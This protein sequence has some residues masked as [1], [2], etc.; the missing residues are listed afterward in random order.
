MPA[1]NR[2]RET[3]FTALLDGLVLCMAWYIFTQVKPELTFKIVERDGI[4]IILAGAIHT[5]Y[6][7][8]VFSLMGLYKQLYL[9]SRFDEFVKVAKATFIGTLILYFYSTI[10]GDMLGADRLGSVIVYVLLVGG[11]ITINRF[12]IRSIQRF[13]AMRGKDYIGH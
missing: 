1:I 3:L 5:V 11:V 10:E 12:V 4:S 2:N 8:I 6:W 9:I 13:Y 7:L